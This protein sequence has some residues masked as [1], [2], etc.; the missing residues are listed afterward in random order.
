MSF[1]AEHVD[2]NL[3]L[4]CTHGHHV[5]NLV[6]QA[7]STWYQPRSGQKVAWPPGPRWTVS[8]PDGCAGLLGGDV[9]VLCLEMEKLAADPHRTNAD[10]KL[11]H[12][13]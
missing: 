8:C 7:I 13:P 3:T 11:K 9:D 6:K 1:Q 4:W 2:G 5:G 10:Y 12:V